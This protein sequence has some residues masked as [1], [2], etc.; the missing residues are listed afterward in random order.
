MEDKVQRLEANLT[1]TTATNRNN[2]SAQR[3]ISCDK[4]NKLPSG[5]DRVSVPTRQED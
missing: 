2:S 3:T 1:R 5:Y 4:N